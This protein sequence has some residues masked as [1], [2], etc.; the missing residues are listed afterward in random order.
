MPVIGWLSGGADFSSYF[1]RL[2]DIPAEFKGD[3]ASYTD[4]KAAG[5]AMIGWGQFI[6]VMINFLIL[7]FIVFLMVR[8]VNR[9]MTPAP[10]PEAPASPSE[11]VLLL[12]EIRDSLRK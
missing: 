5:V 2:G 1:L 10:A 11:E 8:M 4:L 7:A 12:R 6:T 3:P 9:L